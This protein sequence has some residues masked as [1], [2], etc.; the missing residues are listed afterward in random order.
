MPRM[1]QMPFTLISPSIKLTNV[2]K[3]PCHESLQNKSTSTIFLLLFFFNPKTLF[4]LLKNPTISCQTKIHSV[5]PTTK[6][7]RKCLN[8]F[9]FFCCLPLSFFLLM[10]ST[11]VSKP[12]M[13]P[14]LWFFLISFPSSFFFN[15]IFFLLNWFNLF[16]L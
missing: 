15:L 9:F 10:L 16:I 5:F 14:S 11:L 1:S 12:L 6:R 7:T 4:S 13:P 2:S 8:F 3:K